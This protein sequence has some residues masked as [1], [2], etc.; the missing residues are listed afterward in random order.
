MRPISAA[1][2]RT[3]CLAA[4]SSASLAHPQQGAGTVYMLKGAGGNIGL[5][6]TERTT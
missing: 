6:R 3:S 5:C 1:G 4:G 2:R